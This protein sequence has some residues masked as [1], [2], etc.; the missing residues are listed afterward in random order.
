MI[1]IPLAEVSDETGEHCC[2]FCWSPATIVIVYK[3]KRAWL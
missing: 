1:I 2:C 3:V